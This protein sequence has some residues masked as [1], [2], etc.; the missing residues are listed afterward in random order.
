[1][2]LPFDPVIQLLGI[3]LRKPQTLIQKEHK[4][5]SV[6][7]SVIYNC[8]DK[9]AAQVPIQWISFIQWIKQ[10]WDVYT[11]EYH[12]TGKKGNYTLCNSMD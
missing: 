12:L 6:H 7:S 11:I 3:Y 8:Q 9:E 10:L 4:H 5:P 2:N 1:M